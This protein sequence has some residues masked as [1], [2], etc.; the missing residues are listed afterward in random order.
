MYGV[1]FVACLNGDHRQVSAFPH[2]P[3][4]ESDRSTSC[5]K[6]RTIKGQ[7]VQLIGRHYVSGLHIFPFFILYLSLL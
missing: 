6:V 2:G 3:A 1:L 5:N 4:E 7:A